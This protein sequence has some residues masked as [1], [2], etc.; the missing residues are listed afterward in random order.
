[1]KAGITTRLAP[2]RSSFFSVEGDSARAMSPQGP[3]D[4]ALREHLDESPHHVDPRGAAGDDH[5]HREHLQ[6]GVL[7]RLRLAVAHTENGDDHHVDRVEERPAGDHVADDRRHAGELE[8]D[9]AGGDPPERRVHARTMPRG[10]IQSGSI[11]STRHHGRRP[12]ATA[13][14]GIGMQIARLRLVKI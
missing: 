12:H 6:S 11:G 10:S 5:A 14:I 2:E 3:V 7:E 8:E 4:L 13:R 1:M 9:G